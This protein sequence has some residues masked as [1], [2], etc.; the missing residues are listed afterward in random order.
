MRNK[1]LLVPGK[2]SYGVF[3]YMD[4]HFVLASPEA[5]IDFMRHPDEFLQQ[6]K[7]LA[8]IKPEFIHLLRMSD[9]FPNCSL[10]HLLQGKDGSPLFSVTAPLMLDQDCETPV[11]FVDSFI[12]NSYHW[13]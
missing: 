5:V 2:P 7:A 12:D 13:N 9:E 11:H 10:T 4:R 1:G 6:S 3:K 8:R